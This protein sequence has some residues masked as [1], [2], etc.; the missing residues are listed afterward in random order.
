[1]VTKVWIDDEKVYVSYAGGEIMTYP[2][3]NGWLWFLGAIHDR[4]KI[5]IKDERKKLQDHQYNL[6]CER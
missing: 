6:S 4:T 5:V 2:K 1:M 3:D